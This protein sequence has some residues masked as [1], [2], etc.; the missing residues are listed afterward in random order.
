[1]QLLQRRVLASKAVLAD[2]AFRWSSS[3]SMRTREGELS[4][5]AFPAFAELSGA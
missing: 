4:N 1:M 2:V 5:A 3:S